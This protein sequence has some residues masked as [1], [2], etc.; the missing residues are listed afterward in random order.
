MKVKRVN[1]YYCD[2]CTKAGCAGGHMKKHESRCTLNPNRTCGYCKLL[3][4]DQPNLLD[5]ITLVPKIREYQH[6]DE[7]GFVCTLT[8]FDAIAN[9]SLKMVRKK[10]GN[11]PACIMAVYRQAGI[12]MPILTEFNFK[13]EC[14]SI[15]ND[16]N[17]GQRKDYDY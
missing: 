7:F 14:Q 9:E 2:F 16:F 15:W 3:E 8:K 13:K 6:E 10:T 5:I 17:D 1:R 11:C 4:K 12:P